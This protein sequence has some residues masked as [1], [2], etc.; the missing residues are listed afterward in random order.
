[1]G[2]DNAALLWWNPN[3]VGEDETGV[4]GKGMYELVDGGMRYP[5]GK[6][7][8]HAREPLRHQR[9]DNDL[10]RPAAR[11]DAEVVPEPAGLARGAREGLAAAS[12]R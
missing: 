9:R 8:D 11:P 2:L 3:A 6:W 4:V 10:Q 5:G 1:M 7:P 12:V